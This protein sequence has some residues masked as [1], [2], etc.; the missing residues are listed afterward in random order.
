MVPSTRFGSVWFGHGFGSVRFGH[1]LG[2]VWFG[3]VKIVYAGFVH[4]L[5]RS[6]HS[7]LVDLV[8]SLMLGSASQ[9]VPVNSLVK[10]DFLGNGQLDPPETF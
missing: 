9:I 7:W 3:P 2:S 6:V 5:T 4:V 8:G 10:V 1:G